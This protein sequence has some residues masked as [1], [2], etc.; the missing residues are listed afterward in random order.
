MMRIEDNV[1][2][3]SKKKDWK[4]VRRDVQVCY[5]WEWTPGT[6]NRFLFWVKEFTEGK[7]VAFESAKER[8]NNDYWTG[9]VHL[10]IIDLRNHEYNEVCGLKFHS[11]GELEI[12][13]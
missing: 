4:E 5:E 1:S 10:K 13:R 6:Q 2:W 9:I 3:V 8:T 7:P 12:M 11:D